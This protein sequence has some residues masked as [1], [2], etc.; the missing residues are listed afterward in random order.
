[1]RTTIEHFEGVCNSGVLLRRR[2]GTITMRKFQLYKVSAGERVGKPITVDGFVN[3]ENTAKELLQE[4]WDNYPCDDTYIAC[5][6][7]EADLYYDHLIMQKDVFNEVYWKKL[8]IGTYCPLYDRL[9]EDYEE[10]ELEEWRKEKSI[11]LSDLTNEQLQ[12]LRS[13][14]VVG[15]MYLSDYENS[16]NINENEVYDISESYDIWCEEN[17]VEDNAENFADYVQNHL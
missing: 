8:V 14:I 2:K 12:Q 17:G 9:L 5:V 4:I 7:K 13:E 6:E 3:A 15:S 10:D 1:M 11:S 16:F